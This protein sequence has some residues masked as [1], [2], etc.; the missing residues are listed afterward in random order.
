MMVTLFDPKPW[1]EQG[2]DISALPNTIFG[3]DESFLFLND[4]L[5]SDRKAEVS[6]QVNQFL[7]SSNVVTSP[8]LLIPTSGTTSHN[9]K[10]VVLKKEN[11]LNAAKKANAYLKTQ[12]TDNWLVSLP[13]HHVAGLS[14]LA[15]AFLNKNKTYYWNKWD[16][17]MFIKNINSWDISFCSLVPTQI[18]DL[19][20]HNVPAPRNLKTVLVG[21]SALPDSPWQQM[22][23]LGWPLLKT[24]G[25]TETAAFM[26]T[27][28]GD[29]YYDPLPGVQIKLDSN[30]RLVIKTDSL[31]DGY[32]IENGTPGE[33]RTSNV[34]SV[35]GSRPENLLQ[36]RW[37]FDPIQRIDGFWSTEDKATL[38][39]KQFQILGRDQ[40]IIKIKGEL[41]NTQILNQKLTDVAAQ[42]EPGLPAPVVHF[43]PNARD[44]H[45]LFAIFAK[46][47]NEV[48]L[49]TVIKRFNELVLPYERVSWY[50]VVSEIPR[51]DLGKI[52]TSSFNTDSFKESYFENRQSIL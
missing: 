7:Q 27:S 24:F 47:Q 14:I 9:L 35:K 5:S 8:S 21:G 46:G 4:Q 25:M 48:K 37:R 51:T 43:A 52:K 45:E 16:P 44:E 17:V 40:G 12:T 26:S 32:I 31:F 1:L 3:S 50:I 15:R 10:I 39:G 28:Q 20:S 22:K 30:D 36:A 11:F 33:I 29:M 6:A 41:V 49:K 13:L 19:I 2:A 34:G 38:N 23:Q 42:I 18:F